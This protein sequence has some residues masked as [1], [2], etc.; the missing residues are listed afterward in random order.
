MG[1]G[2]GAEVGRKGVGRR[3]HTDEPLRPLAHQIW[4]VLSTTNA[5]GV[6]PQGQGLRITKCYTLRFQAFGPWC[7]WWGVLPVPSTRRSPAVLCS[8]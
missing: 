6:V 3:M 2:E 7:R 8:R 4:R 1:K 5:V